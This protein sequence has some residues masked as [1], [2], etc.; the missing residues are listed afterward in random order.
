ME[1]TKLEKE[2]LY[3]I[4]EITGGFGEEQ[5]YIL[6][7]LEEQNYDIK[8]VRGVIGSLVKKGELIYQDNYI[9]MKNAE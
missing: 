2:I 3:K 6:E 5:K 9:Y 7:C 1:F 8:I 4:D